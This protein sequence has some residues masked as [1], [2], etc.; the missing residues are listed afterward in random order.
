MKQKTVIFEFEHH[1][2]K[3]ICDVVSE[4]KDEIVLDT[5]ITVQKLLSMIEEEEDNDNQDSKS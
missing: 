2:V 3:F 5:G 4:G 1:R